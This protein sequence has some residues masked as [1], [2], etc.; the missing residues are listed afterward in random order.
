[1]GAIK[2]YRPVKDK[3]GKRLDSDG[4]RSVTIPGTAAPPQQ[5]RQ[6]IFAALP[7]RKTR[8]VEEESPATRALLLLVEHFAEGCQQNT[9]TNEKPSGFPRW[10]FGY[11]IFRFFI[12]ATALTPDKL[13]GGLSGRKK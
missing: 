5:A 1:M 12:V 9:H 4:I 10:A 6:R 11:R 3:D 2:A 13:R 8:R 7:E